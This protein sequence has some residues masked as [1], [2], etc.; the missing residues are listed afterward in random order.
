MVNF[1]FDFLVNLVRNSRWKKIWE[2]FDN[3]VCQKRLRA[4]R[5]PR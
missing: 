1:R 2:K 5:Y 3:F 4:T